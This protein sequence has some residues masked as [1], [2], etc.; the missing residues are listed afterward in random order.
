[1]LKWFVILLI[2][3]LAIA[4]LAVAQEEA[5]LTLL[6]ALAIVRETYGEDVVV[7]EM[8][9]NARNTCWSFALLDGTEGCVS[10]A[11][12]ELVDL[13]TPLTTPEPEGSETR[14][15]IS[16]ISLLDDAIESAL[17]IFPR[18]RLSNI[19]LRTVSGRPV[20]VTQLDDGALTV[21]V[22]ATTGNVLSF[23]YTTRLG[24]GNEASEA[25][26]ASGGTQFN[27]WSE[28]SAPSAPP[29]PP[30]RSEPSEPSEPSEASENSG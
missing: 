11:T 6:D 2:V 26:E 15:E 14:D 5:P 24:R 19:Q 8:S 30:E 18:S 10:D 3:V 28:P 27:E 22:S 20:W 16:P 23:G 21:L 12:G 9:Y 25:S 4:G 17:V 13:L 7:A 1:M 29:P